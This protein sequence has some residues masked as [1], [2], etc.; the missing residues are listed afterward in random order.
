MDGSGYQY[1]LSL[2]AGAA[3]VY[4]SSSSTHRGLAGLT[5]CGKWLSPYQQ[6][7]RR[8]YYQRR[9]NNCA[10]SML[11]AGK[12]SSLSKPALA[13]VD[14]DRFSRQRAGFQKDLLENSPTEK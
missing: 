9:K 12:F 4:T 5:E 3:S 13:T 7:S 1:Q 14:D 10:N 8:L 11:K 6:P 2:M